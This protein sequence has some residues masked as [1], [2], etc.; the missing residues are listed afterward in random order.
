MCL[1][2]FGAIGQEGEF[3]CC[4][5]LHQKH[6]ATPNKNW[7]DVVVFLDGREDRFMR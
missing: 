4:P 5:V 1:V 7:S 6:S 2:W 3:S